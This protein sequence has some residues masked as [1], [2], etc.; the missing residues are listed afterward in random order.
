MVGDAGGG[1]VAAAGRVPRPPA[2]A[3]RPLPTPHQPPALINGVEIE[4]PF[5]DDA[6]DFDIGRRRRAGR[7]LPR[8]SLI[9]M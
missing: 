8:F 3:N 7:P 9:A 5:G 2:S 6:N 4:D 1:G